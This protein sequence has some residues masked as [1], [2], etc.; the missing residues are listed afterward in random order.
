MAGL[1]DSPDKI[2]RSRW[3]PREIAGQV[4]VS[5][6]QCDRCHQ[7]SA[8]ADP[9]REQPMRHLPDWLLAH[10]ADPEVVGP[11]VRPP[12]EPEVEGL[13]AAAMAAYARRLY[14]GAPAAEPSAEE[15]AGALVFAGTCIEC[16]T[17]DG[18]G[19]EDG[20]NLSHIGREHDRVW[21]RRWITDPTAVNPNAE[22][23]AF[24]DELTAEQIEA[25]ATYLAARK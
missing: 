3:L 1:R 24:G 15:R 18:D 8:V 22:M 19:G 9:L 4:W 12:P 5:E 25:V 10:V 7:A 11:G 23:P 2:D 13:R 6:A 14:Y 21:L 16:H 17:I 20:P